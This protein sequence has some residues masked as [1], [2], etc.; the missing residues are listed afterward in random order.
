MDPDSENED[1]QKKGWDPEHTGQN[2][3][4]EDA[5]E[6]SVIHAERILR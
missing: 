2:N 3:H 4:A 6:H 1:Q 5:P